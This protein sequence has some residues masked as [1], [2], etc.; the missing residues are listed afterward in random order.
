MPARS[1]SP[2]PSRSVLLNIPYNS[3]DTSIE[4][5][6]DWSVHVVVRRLAKRAS[7]T[8]PCGALQRIR[9]QRL[10][11]SELSRRVHHHATTRPDRNRPRRLDE[12]VAYS[13]VHFRRRIE[14][15][16]VEVQFL[17]PVCR[18]RDEVLAHRT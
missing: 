8:G 13:A 14:E 18:I 9:A 11:P 5:W 17:D 16:S 10:K 2:R 1:T 7:D 3:G 4:F 6:E 15:K 12:R